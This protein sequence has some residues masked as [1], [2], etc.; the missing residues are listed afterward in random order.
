MSKR[1]DVWID[2][3]LGVL[4]LLL[5]PLALLWE[6]FV[7]ART[8]A[9]FLAGPTGL[10]ITQATFAGG[11]LVYYLWR[12]HPS[13]ENDDAKGRDMFGRVLAYGFFVPAWVLFLGWFAGKVLT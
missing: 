3:I 13:K 4:T 8:W 9:W 10:T 12:A 7:Y 5:L 1:D 6:S 2:A 11:L